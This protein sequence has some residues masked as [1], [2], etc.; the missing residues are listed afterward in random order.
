MVS[1]TTMSLGIL[2][3]SFRELRNEQ[4]SAFS[5]NQTLTLAYFLFTI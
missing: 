2:Y 3:P 4:P 1:P 5:N